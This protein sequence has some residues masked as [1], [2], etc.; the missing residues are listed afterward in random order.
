MHY[1][2]GQTKAV[3]KFRGF[4]ITHF[5]HDHMIKLS[6]SINTAL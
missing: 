5:T 6:H 4:Q 3:P 1:A 2:T